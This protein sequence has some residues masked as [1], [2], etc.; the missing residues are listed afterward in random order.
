MYPHSCTP[1]LYC[2]CRNSQHSQRFFFPCLFPIRGRCN[3]N[4]SY[5][6][7]N[8]YHSAR[9]SIGNALTPDILNSVI[10]VHNKGPA[11]MYGVFS[12]RTG[13]CHHVGFRPQ[14]FRRKPGF[15]SGTVA[16]IQLPLPCICP[17]AAWDRV[18]DCRRFCNALMVPSSLCLKSRSAFRLSLMPSP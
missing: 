10:P 5:F 9:P 12:A 13:S 15:F 16:G 6:L 18:P 2:P 8:V 3:N 14:S 11:V 1:I 4:E 17:D 7:Y